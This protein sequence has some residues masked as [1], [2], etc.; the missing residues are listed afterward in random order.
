M[1]L[2]GSLSN[3]LARLLVYGFT[4]GTRAVGQAYRLALQEASSGGGQ[5]ASSVVRGRMDPAEARMILNLR[6]KNTPEELEA[7]F[8]RHYAANDPEK[9]GSKYLRWKVQAAKEVLSSPTRT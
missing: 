2:V 8:T 5:L 6:P 7:A 1:V 3:V 9:G 4:Y